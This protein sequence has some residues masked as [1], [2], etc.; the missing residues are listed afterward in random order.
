MAIRLIVTITAAPGRGSEL[1]QLYKGRCTEVMQEPG[2]EQFEVFQSAVDPDKLVLLE[3][4]SDQA[5]LDE[6]A[7]VNSSRAP[8]PAELRSGTTQREDYQYNRTR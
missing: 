1:A 6:H 3:R 4:W 5:A 7:K 2:C 8:L